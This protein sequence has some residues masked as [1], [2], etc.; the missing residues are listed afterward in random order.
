MSQREENVAPTGMPL[1]PTTGPVTWRTPGRKLT[2]EDLAATS[3][4][5]LGCTCQTC[6]NPAGTGPNDDTGTGFTELTG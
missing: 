4:L 3:A 6:C 2:K 5:I 1:D